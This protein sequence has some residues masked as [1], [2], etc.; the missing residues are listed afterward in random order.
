MIHFTSNQLAE[1]VIW[2]DQLQQA[3]DRGYNWGC[4]LLKYSFTNRGVETFHHCPLG[5]YLDGLLDEGTWQGRFQQKNKKSFLFCL[6]TEGERPTSDQRLPPSISERL[7]LNHVLT[8]FPKK[9]CTLESC[10]MMLN[11]VKGYQ[12]T[13]IATEIDSL[14]NSGIFTIPTSNILDIY[15]YN[16]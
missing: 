9:P 5:V 10:I 11:D 16:T 7:G 6:N 15:H 4:F 14:I 3:Q 8:L 13:Q 12:Y 2:R 1:L